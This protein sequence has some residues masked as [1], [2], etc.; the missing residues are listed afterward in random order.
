[1]RQR[2]TGKGRPKV[3]FRVPPNPQAN[4]DGIVHCEVL[5]CAHRRSSPTPGSRR[6]ASSTPASCT[7]SSPRGGGTRVFFEQSGFESGQAFK[8]A[9]YGW[10]L[11]HGK[12][13]KVLEATAA[14]VSAERR[15]G[16]FRGRG[17]G[18]SDPGKL[19]TGN[20]DG[21]SR[22]V[23]PELSTARHP[24]GVAVQKTCPVSLDRAGRL[25]WQTVFRHVRR[26]RCLQARD[27]R[28]C[29]RTPS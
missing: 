12:L 5:A 14:R 27:Q 22:L 23:Q 19:L 20:C 3:T 4:V 1:L 28:L 26:S 25:V 11:M 7:A 18:E 9:E 29:L 8:G 21:V 6:A 2:A 16:S 10:T 13:A 24:E 17:P 15:D